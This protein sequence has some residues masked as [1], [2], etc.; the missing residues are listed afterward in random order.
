[1]LAAAVALAEAVPVDSEAAA[2]EAAVPADGDLNEMCMERGI[3]VKRGL[4]VFLAAWMVWL[5]ACAVAPDAGNASM[6]TSAVGADGTTS[7]HSTA[8]VITEKATS[9]ASS[10]TSTTISR[11]TDATTPQ[12]TIKATTRPTTVVAD[13]STTFFSTASETADT[14]TV[15]TEATTTT[16]SGVSVDHNTTECVSTTTTTQTSAPSTTTIGVPKNITEAIAAGVPFKTGIQVVKAFGKKTVA[17]QTFTIAQGIATDGEYLFFI[18]KLSKDAG[19]IVVKTDLTG[20]EIAHSARLDLGHANDMTYDHAYDR[21]VIVHGSSSSNTENGNKNGRRITFLDPASLEVTYS[22][23]NNLPSG[24]AAGAI[25]YHAGRFYISR[26]GTAFRIAA[27]SPDFVVTGIANIG[28]QPADVEN[29]TGYTAQGA[30]TDG[31]YIYFPMSGKTDNVVVVY[32]LDGQYVTTFH[33]PTAMES[34]SLVFIE[35]SMYICFNSNG[36]VIAK[37]TLQL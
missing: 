16:T 12:R 13:K 26:G 22:A 24:Y 10:D 5:S 20:R 33:I 17:G 21:L 27:I 15:D 4:A 34:E 35:G 19:A 6:K 29:S 8:A 28:R 3:S 14:T 23:A 32:T 36:A 25:A 1:D 18:L 37:V 30:G 2:P 31:T 9:V 7:A 11:R